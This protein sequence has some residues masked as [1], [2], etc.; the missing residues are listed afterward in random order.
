M[1]KLNVMTKKFV[2]GGTSYIQNFRVNFHNFWTLFLYDII[3]VMIG[4]YKFWVRVVPKIFTGTKR[5]Y[6]FGVIFFLKRYDKDGDE[7]SI[8]PYEM[9]KPDFQLWMTEQKQWIAHIHGKSLNK[10]TPVIKLMATVLLQSTGKKCWWLNS[11][12]KA[13]QIT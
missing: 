11:C 7:F 8:P 12:I 3:T 6:Y 13:P 9:M 10:R 2:K 5:R 1:N 4:Y